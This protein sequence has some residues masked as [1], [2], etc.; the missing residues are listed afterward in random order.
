MCSTAGL[1]NQSLESDFLGFQLETFLLGQLRAYLSHTFKLF[2]I[3]HY[4]ISGS[5][6]IDFIIQT[7]RPVM[8]KRG[9]LVCVEVKFGKKY[10]A[11]W[12]RGLKDFSSLS[13]QEV[14]GSHVVYCG[15]DRLH[16]DGVDVWPLTDFVKA[17]FDGL[18]I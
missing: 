3:F 6:D 14:K 9:D 8:G 13:K 12:I 1:L 17:L 10:R 5:Y 11:D 2:P 15:Q 7:R 18:I 4:S 16:D